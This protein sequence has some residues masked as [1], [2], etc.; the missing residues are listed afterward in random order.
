M[1]SIAHP[2]GSAG[3]ESL[4]ILTYYFDN[5]VGA[6]KYDPSPADLPAGPPTELA[7][8]IHPTTAGASDAGTPR[9]AGGTSTTEAAPVAAPSTAGKASPGSSQG[10]TH[11]DAA[12]S[13][14]HSGSAS[15]NLAVL[16]A[17]A[18]SATVPIDAVHASA[19]AGPSAPRP[20]GHGRHAA[21]QRGGASGDP[22][23]SASGSEPRHELPAVPEQVPFQA[24]GDPSASSGTTFVFTPGFGQQTL[25]DLR[26]AGP[27]HDTIDLPSSEFASFAQ[28]LLDTQDTAQGAVISN[29]G[30][31]DTLLLVGVSKS[32]LAQHKADVSFHA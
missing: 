26:L 20:A 12:T 27:N 25:S 11:T 30:N 17:R 4:D 14:T 5:L 16:D 15:A 3:N 6:L 23:A 24:A 21:E 22:A 29:P 8:S 10:G 1:Q 18:P 9:V 31:G 2:R 28:V 32:E 19:K 7:E 13:V